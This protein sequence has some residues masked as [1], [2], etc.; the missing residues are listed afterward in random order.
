MY[1]DPN[2]AEKYQYKSTLQKG[3]V[4]LNQ[5]LKFIW[6][7]IKWILIIIGVLIAIQIIG[8]TIGYGIGSAIIDVLQSA[9]QKPPLI[10]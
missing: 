4:K 6:S 10:S 3:K 9:V 8:Y 5:V 2:V 7:V 1:L